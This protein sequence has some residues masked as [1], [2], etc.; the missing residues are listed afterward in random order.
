MARRIDGKRR[1]D[2]GKP[3]VAGWPTTRSERLTVTNGPAYRSLDDGRVFRVVGFRNGMQRRLY[4]ELKICEICHRKFVSVHRTRPGAGRFCAISCGKL[5]EY[6][7]M[8]RGVR[9]RGKV[10]RA[11]ADKWFS[12]ITRSAGR[13]L[14]CGTTQYLQCAHVFSRRYYA[15]RWDEKNA[16]CLCRSCHVYFTH[17]P[18]EWEMYITSEI[19]PDTYSALREKAMTYRKPDMGEM[20]DDLAARIQRVKDR[21][22]TDEA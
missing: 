12:D 19:G 20:L 4:G 13:C 7:P 11:T 21:A 3:K 14:K 17:R 2:V 15:I 5:G 10:A 16:V 9:V 8:R 1:N 22:I 18:I 6:N